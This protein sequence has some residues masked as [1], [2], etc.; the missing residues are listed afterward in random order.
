GTGRIVGEAEAEASGWEEQVLTL[1]NGFAVTCTN[2]GEPG[3]TTNLGR[4]TGVL[5]GEVRL[6]APYEIAYEKAKGLVF[7]GEP[8][9]FSAT[10]ESQEAY[11]YHAKS[12]Q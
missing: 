5:K 6:V 9:T 3:E 4:I 11:K 8:G 12:Y 10:L 7:N 1:K 2:G